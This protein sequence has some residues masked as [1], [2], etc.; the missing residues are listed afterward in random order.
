[1]KQKLLAAVSATAI[2]VS[3]AIA[4]PASA[5]AQLDASVME[6]LA[7]LGIDTSSMGAM[8]EEQSAQI[9]NVLGDD[10]PDDQKVD[11]IEE[12][13]G[14]AMTEGGVG[15]GATG[16]LVDSAS[17]SMAALGID[18]EGVESLSVGQLTEIENV[19]AS[20][21]DNDIKRGRIAEII[22]MSEAEVGV[23]SGAMGQ[24]SDSVMAELADLGIDAEQVRG[25]DQDKVLQIENV[26]NTADDEEDKRLRIER[27]LAE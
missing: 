1:M 20:T 13:V 2:A 3:V 12:I 10:I 15:S 16:Q 17:A 18:T 5:Q 19:A 8:S 27:I 25:L 7:E 24:V 11:R 22:G 26:V 9:Q 14:A 6:G 23:G 4:A 21:D